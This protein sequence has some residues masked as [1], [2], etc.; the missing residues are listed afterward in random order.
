MAGFSNTTTMTTT[1]LL[2]IGLGVLFYAALGLAALAIP[3]RILLSVGIAVVKQDSR[4][5]IRAV[6]GG[7]PLAF[8]SLL[9]VAIV[10]PHLASGI[11]LT[12]SMA[13][14]GMAAGRLLSLFLDRGMGTIPMLF[15]AIELIVASLIGAPIYMR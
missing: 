8:A 5:E 12:I 4:N 7:L 6:Y 9:C 1:S 15:A 10:M 3:N 11:L 2:C 13:T 14:L